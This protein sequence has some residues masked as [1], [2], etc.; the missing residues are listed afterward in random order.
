MHLVPAVGTTSPAASV[1]VPP[2][3]GWSI[4]R[5]VAVAL[6]TTAAIGALS[7]LVLLVG[8]GSAAEEK[9]PHMAPE[10]AV[11]ARGPSW[12]GPTTFRCVYDGTGDVEYSDATP[13]A[14]VTAVFLVAGG[15]TA[16]VWFGGVWR[17][18]RDRGGSSG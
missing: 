15:M 10:S 9:C 2:R 11:A 3:S 13:L 8:L 6:A 4:A 5:R 17:P 7:L 1:P 12:V 14:A 18:L 16:A